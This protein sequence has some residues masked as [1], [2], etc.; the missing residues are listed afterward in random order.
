VSVKADNLVMQGFKLQ[1]LILIV[2]GYSV[3]VEL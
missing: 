3:L 1:D 2:K